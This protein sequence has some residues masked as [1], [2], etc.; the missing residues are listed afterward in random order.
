LTGRTGLFSIGKLTFQAKL[1]YNLLS[2]YL[3]VKYG[4]SI[5]KN[6]MAIPVPEINWQEIREIEK[7]IQEKEDEGSAGN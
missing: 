6:L 3:I 5:H 4:M 2:E 7:E 1:M